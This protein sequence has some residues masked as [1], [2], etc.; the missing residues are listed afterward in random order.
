[1]SI[2]I[3]DVDFF[4]AFNDRY[5]HT[6]GD[7]CLQQVARQ[8]QKTVARNTDI[9]ARFGG[10]E[11]ICILTD[12]DSEGA[13]RKAEQIHH[14]IHKLQIKHADSS[15]GDYLTLSLGVATFSFLSNTDWSSKT[16]IEE[17]DR[18]LYQAKNSGRNKSCF[19]VNS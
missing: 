18:A 13:K 7:S 19:S 10:E 14:A 5:G 12:T 3:A 9:C 4:K 6:E 1:L 8:L 2:I 16:I 11:F 15:V 17:A